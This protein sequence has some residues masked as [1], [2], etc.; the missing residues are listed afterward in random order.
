MLSDLAP[1]KN[2]SAAEWIEERL[3]GASAYSVGGVVPIGFTAYARI[4]HPAWRTCMRAGKELL[5]PVSWA[6]VAQFT[7]R[8]V[9]PL[10]QWEGVIARPRIDQQ[11]IHMLLRSGSSIVQDPDEGSIPPRISC[12]L[13]AILREHV[14]N[15]ANCW[16]GVWTGYGREYEFELPSPIFGT[17]FREWYLL[18]GSLDAIQHS[19]LDT[20][21]LGSRFHQSPNI[22]WPAE[23]TW[24]VATDIDLRTTYVG[25]AIE[26][27]EAILKDPDIEAHES[28]PGDRV[29][30]TSDY[31]NSQRPSFHGSRIVLE[32]P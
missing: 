15:P 29:D 13:A 10:M 6:E 17:R 1:A 23:K 26:L 30:L 3:Q 11:V 9:H 22:A 32:H 28:S 7:E 18:K 25:G 14:S 24:C 12:R 2:S 8:T 27:I 5:E 19:F 31:I 21:R 16:F 4:F 20:K